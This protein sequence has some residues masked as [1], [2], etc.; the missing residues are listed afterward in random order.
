VHF[1]GLFAP[2][3]TDAWNTLI[4]LGRSDLSEDKRPKKQTIYVIF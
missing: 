2:S 1:M 4:A 3:S